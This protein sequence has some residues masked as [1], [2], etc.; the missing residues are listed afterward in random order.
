MRTSHPEGFSRVAPLCY[1]PI[2][3]TI[4]LA[5]LGTPQLQRDGQP[6]DL[7]IAKVQALLAYLAVTRRAQSRDQLLGLL[8]TESHTDAARKNLRNRLWQ[9]RQSLGDEA[10][11][12]DGDTLAL[13]PTV[14]SDVAAF[15]TGIQQQLQHGT[16]DAHTLEALLQLW[17]GPLLD[18][19]VLHEAP[20]FE[21]WL[22][23]E[24]AQLGQLYLQALTA[25]LSLKRQASDWP[26]VIEAAQRGLHYDP[27]HEPLHQQLIVAYTQQGLR[28]AALRQYEQLKSLLVTELNVA[29][30]PATQAL[31]AALL[32]QHGAQS[33]DRAEPTPTA[34]RIQPNG[35]THTTMV[36]PLMVS[37]HPTAP[38]PFIG[39]QEQLAALDRA[40]VAAQQGQARVVLLSGELGMGKTTLWQQWI[41]GLTPTPVVLA[42]RALN[43]TQQL[44]FEPMRR[45]LGT[46][47]CRSQLRQIADQLLPVWR[48]ELRRLA[49]NLQ[50]VLPPTTAVPLETT[51]SPLEER[52]LI[53]E[54]LTQFLRAFAG[55]PLILFIDD[56]HWADGATLDWL[57]YLTDRMSA[58]PL[59]LVG[60]YR[61]QDVTPPLARLIAQWQRDG[62]LQ[63]I[64]LPSFTST[65][66]TTL[67]TA[68]GSNAPMAEYL[69]MQSGGNPY[70][71]TQ[72][73]DIAVDGVP[74]TLA[75]LV[76]ARLS[77]LAETW[78]PVLQAAAILE[79]TIEVSLLAQT[80]GRSEESTIDALD[81]LLTAGI[82]IERGDGYEFAHGLVATVVREGLSNGRRKLLHRR[83][84]EGLFAHHQPSLM[85]V[86]GQVAGQ[87]A[88]HY[89]AAGAKFE[90]ARFAELAGAEAL[91]IGAAQEAVTF[92]EQAHTLHPTPD[93]QLGLGM[94]L[95][96]LPG[97]IA[98][99]RTIMEAA[100]E[101]YETL[102][103]AQGAI[104]AGLRLATS[105]LGT[106]EGAQVLRWARRVLPDL[107]VVADP[108]LHASAHYLMGTAKFRNGYDLGEAEQHYIEATRLVTEHALDSEIALMSWF[109]WGNLSLERGDYAQAL[110]KFRQAQQV[111]QSGKSIL[112]EA[113]SL[114]NLAYATLL[115][116]AVANA[117]RL[118]E[119][120]LSLAQTYALRPIYYY[121]L[122]TRGE[123]ALARGELATATAS[124][125][126]AM[127][128]AE[129]YENQTFMANLQAHLGRAAQA[130]GDLAEA[131]HLLSAAKAALATEQIRHLQI[132]IDLW[133]TALLFQRS[134]LARAA[135]YLQ[136]AEEQL[137]TTDYRQL[138]ATAAHLRAQLRT[139]LLQP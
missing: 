91:R 54:A 115:T 43:T 70:Y 4:R 57:L 136:M 128:L 40:R 13:S 74:A 50:D 133:L 6:L 79:P 10:I 82:M 3:S 7:H 32:N 102:G 124:F 66:T 24:R 48:A 69:H 86:T 93:R 34:A 37:P 60:A 120:A 67:L 29:P 26:G 62:L 63:R 12:T 84:A 98:A 61:A 52:G 5:F 104:K 118:I 21:L 83:A 110:D 59:L 68:L 25:L 101:G 33:S 87:L 53:A 23:T 89:G 117:Q 108:T 17:R 138:K 51:L 114:N 109:E 107:E 64:D 72:L 129:K 36:P 9:L 106:Q 11:L 76:Q 39:R 46:L 42:T 27:L 18:G 123:I 49:P 14:W 112:F 122:S 90:A 134:E 99:A 126:E 80:S 135:K 85:P 116:G 73:S 105:Y 81:G 121:L 55:N 31:H 113:L 103:N 71:L 100:L 47:P 127:A 38:K 2:M 97:K 15:V 22:A 58:E 75:E 137:A 92:Y 96:L 111:A 88:Y 16:P 65:E 56:L 44:P 94:A 132:Q 130:Q 125:T 139:G 119:A 30:L 78:Q 28:A 1:N 45:L 77:Y 41:A 35:I 19:V 95:M 8:W 20:E 131:E